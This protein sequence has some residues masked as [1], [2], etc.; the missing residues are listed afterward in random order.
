MRCYIIRQI[1]HE[2]ELAAGNFV[3]FAC[4]IIHD[5]CKHNFGVFHSVKTVF[6]D[7]AERFVYF[8][9]DYFFGFFGYF[10]RERACARA[11][12][13]NRIALFHARVGNYRGKQIVVAD[14]ILPEFL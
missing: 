3:Y 14:K 4:R 7:G 9:R 5:V 8:K 6:E 2:P 11:Y 1:C 13:D 10:P 12:F